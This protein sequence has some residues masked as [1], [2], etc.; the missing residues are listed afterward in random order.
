MTHVNCITESES[1]RRTR[2]ALY[3]IEQP[4]VS[5]PSSNPEST[6]P[7][8]DP[9]AQIAQL[10]CRVNRKWDADQSP[11]KEEF[12]HDLRIM[13]GLD[14]DHADHG[15]FSRESRLSDAQRA[16]LIVAVSTLLIIDQMNV[17]EEISYSSEH[18]LGELITEHY[19]SDENSVERFR[20][21]L[22]QKMQELFEGRQ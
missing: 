2:R 22:I 15:I 9:A 7:P 18:R 19:G 3:Y 10:V 12:L 6:S 21:A 8:L 11:N 14:P 20:D 4:E 5:T 16:A 13:I 1:K 17:P